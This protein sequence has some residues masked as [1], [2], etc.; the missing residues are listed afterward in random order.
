VRQLGQARDGGGDRVPVASAF[1]AVGFPVLEQRVRTR[2]VSSPAAVCTSE[3]AAT[4]DAAAV[5]AAEA[6]AVALATAAPVRNQQYSN[7]TGQLNQDLYSS[8]RMRPAPRR[9]IRSA[10]CTR[11]ATASAAT[12]R[13]LEREVLTC[14]SLGMRATAAAIACPS[15]A[16]SQLSTWRVSSPGAARANAS[17]VFPSRPMI[18]NKRSWR[19]RSRSSCCCGA[20][21]NAVPNA[22]KH[23]MLK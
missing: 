12:Q 1:P 7:M 15:L 23:S 10:G 19:V 11:C 21:D 8:A 22:A 2:A 16:R 4:S 9:T 13:G 6:S 18:S 17:S 14:A 5:T 20:S 3:L